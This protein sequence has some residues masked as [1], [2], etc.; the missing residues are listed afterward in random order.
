MKGV[1]LISEICD[2]TIIN[3]SDLLRMGFNK[4]VLSLEMS[5]IRAFTHYRLILQSVVGPRFLVRET[6]T[7][8]RGR[9]VSTQQHFGNFVCLNDRFGTL[10]GSEG[11]PRRHPL[12]S[13]QSKSYDLD[14]M[15]LTSNMA[16]LKLS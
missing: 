1:D 13:S 5:E 15:I 8:W 9:R 11:V 2:I 7:P 10:T 4:T 16:G 6:L 3:K 14:L 12:G